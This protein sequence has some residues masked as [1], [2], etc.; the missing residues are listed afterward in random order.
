MPRFLSE[1]DQLQINLSGLLLI[2]LV[3][4]IWSWQASLFNSPQEVTIDIPLGTAALIEKDQGGDVIPELIT[5]QEGDSLVLVNNDEEGHRVGGLFVSEK[6]TV[7][8]KFKD[9]GTYSYFCSVHPSGQTVF[10]V[11]ERN[12]I[13]P[14]GWTLFALI[15]ILGAVNG[16]IL[17]ETSGWEGMAMIVVGVAALVSGITFAVN[18]SGTLGKTGPITDNPIPPTSESV[19]AG[20]AVYLQFCSLCHG[21]STLGDGP[22]AAGLN[23]PPADLV[24]HVPL[25]PDNVL[26]QY[27]Q[28][29][30]PGTSMPPLGAGMSD[31][32]AWHLVN[33]LRTL[34]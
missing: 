23:P 14:L 11:G 1:I 24:I 9:P 19:A 17:L 12:S 6:S 15:G 29:G 5:L 3:A 18:S 16:I 10:E 34:R 21:E 8:A 32:E 13:I 2:I 22:A 27:I 26:F 7:R 4:S 28:E 31:E 20:L 25:H 33:Y 30:I